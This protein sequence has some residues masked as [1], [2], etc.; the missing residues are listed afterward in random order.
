MGHLIMVL[1][2]RC[3][4]TMVNSTYLMRKYIWMPKVTASFIELIRRIIP[5]ETPM[6]GRA[7]MSLAWGIYISSKAYIDMV[8]RPAPP[9]TITCHSLILLMMGPTI[10]QDS[11]ANHVVESVNGIEEDRSIGQLGR[12]IKQR[13]AH[14]GAKD[15]GPT[16]KIP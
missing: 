3:R 15:S 9:S 7:S 12:P 14:P 4:L 1:E 6:N 8:L 13:H 5:M 11:G 16:K 10:N 2:G